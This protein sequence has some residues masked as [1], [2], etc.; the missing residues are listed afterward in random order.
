[1]P[2]KFAHFAIEADDVDR[3]RA[4]YESVFG[5]RFEAWGPPEFYLIHGAGVHGALQKRPQSLPDGK[6]GFECSIAVTDLDAS[7]AAITKAGGQLLGPKVTIP[8]VGQLFSFLDPEGNR[9]III[10]YEPERA[11]E[12]GLDR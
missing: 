2:N 7:A 12:L 8:T 1:M 3:A 11:T 5:W 9:A 4:F 6:R 10:Q